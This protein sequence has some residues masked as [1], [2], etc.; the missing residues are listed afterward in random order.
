VKMP[1]RQ[2]DHCS[3]CPSGFGLYCGG[4]GISGEASTLYDCQPTGITVREKCANRCVHM[5]AGRN[6]L[7]E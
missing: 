7:C 1:A 4:N 3:A 6:D 2:N 5:P